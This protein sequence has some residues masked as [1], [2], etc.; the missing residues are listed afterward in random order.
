ME[1]AT[2]KQINALKKF[3]KNPELSKGLL[4]REVT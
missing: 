2:E 3:A 4:K 1:E